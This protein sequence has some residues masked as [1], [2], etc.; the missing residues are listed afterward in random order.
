MRDGRNEETEMKPI[1]KKQRGAHKNAKSKAGNARRREER[2]TKAGL[3]LKKCR[4]LSIQQ[5]LARLPVNGAVR[6]R[7][8]LT[9]M[10]QQGKKFAA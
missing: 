6:E 10:L 4:S 9:A 1:F 2:R 8:R 5:R 3:L 7:A